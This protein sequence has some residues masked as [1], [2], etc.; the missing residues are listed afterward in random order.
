MVEKRVSEGP[1]D[2]YVAGGFLEVGHGELGE[3][4]LSQAVLILLGLL[5]HGDC[6]Q[7]D[8]GQLLGLHVQ[9]LGVSEKEGAAV[10]SDVIWQ[11]VCIFGARERQEDSVWLSTGCRIIHSS[12]SPAL[13]GAGPRLVGAGW[14]SV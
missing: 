7:V 2:V 5:Q 4:V 8:L 3:G 12:P 1:P 9:I 10:L 14:A 6:V 13:N 11:C